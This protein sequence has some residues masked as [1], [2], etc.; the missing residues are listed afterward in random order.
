MAHP[1]KP[2]P[3]QSGSTDASNHPHLRLAEAEN[4]PYKPGI[5]GLGE[6]QYQPESLRIKGFCGE[7]IE[8]M[9]QYCHYLENVVFPAARKYGEI[10]RIIDRVIIKAGLLLP[11]ES[12]E[13]PLATEAVV[14]LGGLWEGYDWAMNGA[15]LPGR[16]LTDDTR[17]Q[18]LTQAREAQHHT[19]VRPQPLQEGFTMH[20]ISTASLSEMD[21]NDLAEIF[22]LSFNGYLTPLET[23]DQ[24]RVWLAGENMYPVAVRNEKGKIVVV[25]N[26][27]FA[28]ITFENDN[29]QEFRFLEI[30]DS[31]SHP[32][33]RGQGINRHVK[34]FLLT[35]A[36]KMGFH[37]IHT[38][39]RAAWISPNIANSK[40]GMEYGGTL[41]SNCQ[42]SGPENI[43]ETAD[44]NLNENSRRMGS[45]NIWAMTPLNPQW[46]Y[47]LRLLHPKSG[48]T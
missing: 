30:G 19:F 2:T 16:V 41:W 46:D 33:Y 44:P 23:P 28:R 31:A 7:I 29:I 9:S 37:S 17:R 48:N 15:S 47:Y 32:D 13:F 14:H 10:T 45:L 18:L 22:R 24:V 36:V 8:T 5:G 34:H 4:K 25:A 35:E 40:N 20:K 3:A 12:L 38:E 11:K 43:L 27:D 1:E 26:G 6:P 42:I 39:T 21:I